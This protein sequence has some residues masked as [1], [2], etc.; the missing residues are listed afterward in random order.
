MRGHRRRVYVGAWV[1][2][3]RE[4]DPDDLARDLFALMRGALG[5]VSVNHVGAQLEIAVDPRRWSVSTEREA[6]G[7]LM[8]AIA[9]TINRR[10]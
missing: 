4:H 9:T 1:D 6:Q 5:E 3:E 8:S 2:K 7:S 10:G